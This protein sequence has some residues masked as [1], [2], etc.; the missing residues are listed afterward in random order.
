MT[1]EKRS[2][3]VHVCSLSIVCNLALCALGILLV[4]ALKLKILGGISP[5][6]SLS[7]FNPHTVD[8]HQIVFVAAAPG[9]HSK[10][11]G[12]RLSVEQRVRCVRLF[13]IMGNVSEVQRRML[14]EFGPPAVHRNTI[15]QIN[16]MFDRTG[17]ANHPKNPGPSRSVR[18]QDMKN[19]LRAE[20]E[21]SPHKSKSSRRLSAKLNIGKTSVLRMLHEMKHTPYHPRLIHALNE[22]DFDRRIEFS[23]AWLAR[24]EGDPE[25]A[26]N[27]VWTDEAIFHT[28]GS[29]NRHNCVFWRADNPHITI[30]VEHTSPGVMVWA[31][32]SY[33]GIVGPHFL[34]GNVTGD[35]YLNLLVNHVIPELQNRENFH[36]MWWQQDGAPPHFATNVR[37]FLDQQFPNRWLGRRGPVEWP[38]RSPDLTPPDFFLWGYLKDKVYAHPIVSLQD[39]CLAIVEEF[40]KLPLQMCQHA[41]DA[42]AR[43]LR[44]CIQL[45][46]R[47]VG[48]HMENQ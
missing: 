12:R 25:V 3:F 36:R 16:Q 48:H 10:M 32:V 43:R 29:V 24:L 40:G 41:C 34:E 31:G 6:K 9:L 37:N 47:Q 15:S 33:D 39:L 4:I 42:V 28:S 38:P 18:T 21:S 5:Q 14:E 45:N 26:R 30:E 13:S 35:R 1:C 2:R 20:L 8:S 23:E 22:D 19:R 17:S 27:V 11:A 44:T 7:H 46:G